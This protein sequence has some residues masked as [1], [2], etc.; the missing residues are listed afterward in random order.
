MRK[1]SAT[2]GRAEKK[3][4]REV[5]IFSS[6]TTVVPPQPRIQKFLPVGD[7]FYP[8]PQL[9]PLGPQTPPP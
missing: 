9:S 1:R 5:K 3:F 8:N 2:T 4:P 6:T 7:F